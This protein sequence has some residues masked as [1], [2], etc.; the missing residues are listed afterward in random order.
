M[1]VEEEELGRL[2]EEDDFMGRG[3]LGLSNTLVGRLLLH[4]LL[5]GG[6]AGGRL[7]GQWVA[8]AV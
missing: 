3:L 7:C 5:L 4:L 6:P 1:A 8:W 2:E